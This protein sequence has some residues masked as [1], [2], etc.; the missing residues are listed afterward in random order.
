[1]VDLSADLVLLGFYAI[2]FSYERVFPKQ[3]QKAGRALLSTRFFLILYKTPVE[4]Q[5]H[6]LIGGATAT[7][8]YKFLGRDRLFRIMDG[9]SDW[10]EGGIIDDKLNQCVKDGSPKSEG[11]SDW[12]SDKKT[13][14]SKAANHWSKSATE[15]D[16]SEVNSASEADPSSDASSGTTNNM[17]I[18]RSKKRKKRT[19]PK[20]QRN[21]FRPKLSPRSRKR[22]SRARRRSYDYEYKA[23]VVFWFDNY[24]QQLC[25]KQ[26]VKGKARFPQRQLR[27]DK[28]NE[29]FGLTDTPRTM[30]KW[31]SEEGRKKIEV[32]LQCTIANFF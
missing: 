28:T 17:P 26:H 30:E 25:Q 23:K 13:T 10:E 22:K 24:T 9:V 7:G 18:S 12:D 8:S 2:C 31:I 1:M 11:V 20:N 14:P 29:E 4:P 21:T 32:V 19:S 5:S 27:I 16:A 3:Q 15:D 6:N